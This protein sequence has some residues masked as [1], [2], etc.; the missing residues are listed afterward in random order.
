[1]PPASPLQR[2]PA[3]LYT[4]S[5]KGSCPRR[6]HYHQGRLLR[7]SSTLLQATAGK[8][9][10]K[11]PTPPP[12]RSPTPRH[13]HASAGCSRKTTHAGRRRCPMP[14]PAARRPCW[15]FLRPTTTPPHA[16]A[17]SKAPSPSFFANSANVALAAHTAASGK[18][19]PAPTLPHAVANATVFC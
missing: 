2:P 15:R 3:L 7:R 5:S 8:H 10:R 9:T 17:S 12:L 14:T 18:P 6:R 16:A 4:Q 11:L 19:S 13:M 1:M